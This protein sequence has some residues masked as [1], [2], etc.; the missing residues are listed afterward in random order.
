MIR[1]VP[2][3]RARQE[4][5][6][7]PREGHALG[8]PERWRDQQMPN[9][10]SFACAMNADAHRQCRSA[11]TGEQDRRIEGIQ[12]WR[13]VVKFSVQRKCG[14]TTQDRA[15]RRG[16]REVEAERGD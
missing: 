9:G 1:L 3:V 13:L 16:G 11:P 14:E 7:G 6:H 5:M 12:L 8:C 2:V 15:R 4:L 10:H